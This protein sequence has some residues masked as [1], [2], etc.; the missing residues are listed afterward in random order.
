MTNNPN[1]MHHVLFN[2]LDD[3]LRDAIEDAGGDVKDARGPWDYPEIIKHQ[4]GPKFFEGPGIEIVERNGKKYI[5]ATA[6]AIT[7]GALKPP[8]GITDTIQSGTSIQSI[9]ETLFY[10]I[11]PKLNSLYKGDVIKADENGKDQYNEDDTRSGLIPGATYLRL[12]IMSRQE[13]IYVNLSGHGLVNEESDQPS[14]PQRE[15]QGGETE[16]IRTWIE[17]DKIYAELTEK[18]EQKFNEIQAVSNRVD[19]IDDSIEEIERHLTSVDTIVELLNK[20][21]S[22]IQENK[23]SKLELKEIDEKVNHVSDEISSVNS[24][25][26]N[27]TNEVNRIEREVVK[28]VG[29]VETVEKNLQIIQETA[30]TQ[31]IVQELVTNEVNQVVK[32]EVSE[33]KI[34]VVVN[35]ILQDQVATEEEMDDLVDNLFK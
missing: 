6:G 23:A 10:D 32:E 22:D 11:L 24:L 35:N 8:Y 3:E 29:N 7:T 26:E 1:L 13:P 4:L 16:Y 17:N 5:C 27:T 33:E 9:F 19:L 20:N 34:K 2:K 12:Y 28:I 31:E 21:I 30:V 14:N 25:I 15:L 18:G